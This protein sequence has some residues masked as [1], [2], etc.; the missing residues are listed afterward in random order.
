[1]YNCILSG[2]F[3]Y[4]QDY[5][6]EPEDV[7]FGESC[8]IYGA[9]I[10]RLPPGETRDNLLKGF[11]DY[12]QFSSTLT[13]N[14]PLWYLQVNTFMSPMEQ[15]KGTML[16]PQIAG[17]NMLLSMTDRSSALGFI[18]LL[19]QISRKLSIIRFSHN[20]VTSNEVVI[21]S[22]ASNLLSCELRARQI[23]APKPGAWNDNSFAASRL[24]PTVTILCDTQ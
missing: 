6:S 1:M 14:P 5:T 9:L 4:W 18:A 20:V 19:N 15:G 7:R 13:D 10:H 12:L 3:R 8:E 2:N 24:L 21:P 17:A 16:P 11:I 23:P 22:G